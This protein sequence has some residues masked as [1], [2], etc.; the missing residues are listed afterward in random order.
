ML[1]D[2]KRV[3]AGSV[4]GTRGWDLDQQLIFEEDDDEWLP[5]KQQRPSFGPPDGTANLVSGDANYYI[6]LVKA[7][8]EA[9]GRLGDHRI[10]VHWLRMILQGLEGQD[11]GVD[12]LLN[13]PRSKEEAPG[14]WS[15]VYA[16]LPP[17]GQ[18]FGGQE[19]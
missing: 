18:F 1:S 2:V 5:D 15:Q 8:I 10:S 14:D 17:F 13:T 12:Y 7:S 6:G 19:Q 9:D 4:K 16:G 11:V 3:V